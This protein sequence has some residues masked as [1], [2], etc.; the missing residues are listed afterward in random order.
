MNHEAQYHRRRMRN[1]GLVDEAVHS[2]LR[3]HAIGEYLAG[4]VTYN[5]GEYPAPF[6]IAPTD[7]DVDLLQTFARH[8]VGLI[9]LHEEW[10]DSQRCLGADKFSS[11]DP[12]GLREFVDLAHSLGMKV[13]LYASTGFFEATDPDFRPEWSHPDSHLVE[14]YFD[15]ARC[16]PASPEWRAYVLPRL[17]RVMDENGVD[18]LYDDLGYYPL[19]RLASTDPTHVGLGPETPTQDSALEDLLGIVVDLVH[20]HGGILK[21]HHGGTRLLPGDT[22]D[23]LWVGEGV[24]SLSDLRRHCGNAQPYVVPCPDMSRASVAKED[25]LYLHAVPTMQFPPRVD[26]RPCTGQ[27]AAVEGMNYRRGEACFWTQHMRTVWRHVQDHP[28]APPMYGW[29]D[30]FPGRQEGRARW[31]H[32]L[33]LYRPMVSAGS[34]VWLDIRETSLAATAIPEQVTAS[35]FVNDDIYLVLANYGDSC[36]ALASPREW[37][38]R[39]TGETGRVLELESGTLR[40]LRLGGA[41]GPAARTAG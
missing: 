33:D 5:L 20:R 11:H 9:Q 3:K 29:W 21:L 17:E 10:N 34:R 27:R 28:E 6:S 38:D 23:Y 41:D 12:E 8:G 37:T 25:D 14:L 18:G 24:D 31:L 22:Y 40:Y 30:S 19:H 1:I 4:Q 7:Y 26:G 35:L 2:C 36:V 16:S 32:H 39:E 15:Y 13:L